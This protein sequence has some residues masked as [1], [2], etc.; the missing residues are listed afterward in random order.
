MCVL[1][2]H[3]VRYTHTY[4]CPFL[5]TFV[6]IVTP[7]GALIAHIPYASKGNGTW[8]RHATHLLYHHCFSA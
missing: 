7:F 2:A 6:A 5:L 1:I 8:P 3:I 4:S